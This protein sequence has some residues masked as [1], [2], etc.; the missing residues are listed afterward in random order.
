M[1]RSQA[2]DLLHR[3]EID[4]EGGEL[5]AIWDNVLSNLDYIRPLPSLRVLQG[6]VYAYC[7]GLGL[8]F[9]ELPIMLETRICL[10]I[11]L[12]AL[13]NAPTHPH[14]PRAIPN[15]QTLLESVNDSAPLGEQMDMTDLHSITKQALIRALNAICMVELMKLEE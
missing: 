11:A 1:K 15:L 9:R 13:D 2:K 3:I 7:T 8:D 6:I 10:F 12:Y 5:A 14:V 4:G